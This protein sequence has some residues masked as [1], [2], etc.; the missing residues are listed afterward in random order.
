MEQKNLMLWRAV[1]IG[2]E[3]GFT[4][5][6]PL[7][8]LLLIGK[9]LDKHF[10]TSPIFLLI[11]LSLSFIISAISLYRTVNPILKDFNKKK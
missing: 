3:L 6:I 5:A 9:M 7:V 2:S 1:K 11:G 8:V 10:H 4:I